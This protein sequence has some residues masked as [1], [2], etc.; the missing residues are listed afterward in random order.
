MVIESPRHDHDITTMPEQQARDAL[1]TCRNRYRTLAADSAIG[2]VT[3]FRN[4]GAAAG[5]SLSHPH[6][7]LIALDAVAPVV[8]ARQA[9]MLSYY[10]KE[11][12]CIICDIIGDEHAHGCRV[13]NENDAFLTVVPF[14]ANAPCEM[15]L[16]PKHHQ[17]DFGELPEGNVEL[18]AI[19][20][21]DALL[22]LGRTLDDPPYTYVI[23]TAAKATAGAAA[24]HWRLR[25]TPRVIVPAG[26]ELGAGL[27]INPSLP[28]RDAALLRAVLP[29]P[30]A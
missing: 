2:S 9:A 27:P 29:R 21:R 26:F 23:D 1:A 13:V 3:V 18:L 19:A 24:L 6:T 10:Q 5:A 15:W 30:S 16:L 12:R 4:R 8:R 22:R 20:L 11:K 28:E 25:I 17:A 7:Q 14:A